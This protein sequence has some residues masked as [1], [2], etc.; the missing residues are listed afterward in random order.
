[1][2]FQI[3][4]FKLLLA[5]IVCALIILNGC[6]GSHEYSEEN[7]ESENEKGIQIVE[8]AKEEQKNEMYST[9]N[10]STF[11]YW[12]NN[13]IHT[14]ENFSKCNIFAMNVLYKAGCK[15]PEVNVTTYDLMDTT[16]FGDILPLVKVSDGKNILK[17]DLLDIYKSMLDYKLYYHSNDEYFQLN[18]FRNIFYTSVILKEYEWAAEFLKNYMSELSHVQRED[19]IHYSQ[20]ILKEKILI[21]LWKK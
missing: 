6:S 11:Y 15:C 7:D 12:L 1:L 18:L 9:S 19:M 21:K 16:M 10:D 13:Q 4:N 5:L 8:I 14:L 3:S 2:K 17:G 20:A